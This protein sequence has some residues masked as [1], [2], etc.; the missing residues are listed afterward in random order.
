VPRRQ[1]YMAPG[2]GPG[3]QQMSNLSG[4][5]QP[6]IP[7]GPQAARMGVRPASPMGGVQAGAGIGG[8][9]QDIL[10][11]GTP[12][13]QPVPTPPAPIQPMGGGPTSPM[14]IG[15]MLQAQKVPLPQWGGDLPAADQSAEQLPEG[16]DNAPDGAPGQ[17]P[18]PMVLLKL[19]KAMGAA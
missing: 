19:L 5:G 2:A 10:G 16:Y 1:P 6:A 14:N 18:V 8:Q 3:Q 13:Q 4:E 12:G 15:P 17:G 7:M 9:L 11:G